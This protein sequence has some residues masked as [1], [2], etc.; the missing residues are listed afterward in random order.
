MTVLPERGVGVIHA[1][2]LEPLLEAGGDLIDV[3]EIE[4]QTFWFGGATVGDLAAPARR[5]IE[6]AGLDERPALVHGVGA[7]IGG[8][9]PPTDADVAN[10]AAV[11]DLLDSAWVSEHLSFNHV[12]LDGSV[13]ATG[14]MLPPVQTDES[15]LLAATSI[16]SVRG[17]LG[18]PFAFETGVNY[19]APRPDEVPDGVWWRT[20]AE[21]ADCGILLDLH[22][23]WCNARNG[24][25]ALDELFDD[26]PLD[27]VWEIHLAGGE[28]VDGIWLDAHSGLVDPELLA[29][30]A[31]VVAH[32]PS[33]RAITFEIVPEYLLARDVAAGDIRSMLEQ[34]HL[35]WDARRTAPQ[36]IGG[37]EPPPVAPPGDLDGLAAAEVRLARAVL[38][39]DAD[40][41]PGVRV[42]SRL[43][44]AIRRGLTVTV[45][46]LSIR[47]VRL[48][49]GSDAVAAALT[50]C[51]RRHTP[52][53]HADA[54]AAHVA[55]VL[56]EMYG[57]SVAHLHSVLDYELALVDLA[58]TGRARPVAFACD[59]VA[60]LSALG[61]GELPDDLSIGAF[62]L[63][64]VA[65]D[66]ITAGWGVPRPSS[67]VW[68]HP[69]EHQS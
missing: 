65:D 25:Q 59:P 12:H 9:I 4:P 40:A 6:A 51:H 15:A 58:R 62:E 17:G 14:L 7:P 61:R 26:L 53:L 16:A 60:L 18:R 29:I 43:V 45:L 5:M 64:L 52:E 28:Q 34:L 47:L 8:T 46:P 10:L 24:R 30:A 22:N 69:W 55:V 68:R 23:V 19:L 41:E 20:I 63:D 39:P 42:M 57:S 56:R 36:V 49:R 13:A 48:T 32:L 35:L 38:D 66:A 37:G 44:D 3:V 27:R 50:E 31:D 33:L 2:G 67:R 21:A 1:P 11:T 54:E